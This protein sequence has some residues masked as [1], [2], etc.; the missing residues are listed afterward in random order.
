MCLGRDVCFIL[1]CLGHYSYLQILKFILAEVLAAIQLV[2]CRFRY[3]SKTLDLFIFYFMKYIFIILS[4]LFFLLSTFYNM[5][6]IFYLREYGFVWGFHS[7]ERCFPTSFMSLVISYCLQLY[8]ASRE[9]YFYIMNE[10][11][12]IH[13][14]NESWI[15]RNIKKVMAKRIFLYTFVICIMIVLNCFI[16]K[17]LI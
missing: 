7:F 8:L 1:M 2:E 15:I 16:L 13:I 6:N 11:W 10:S 9:F 5:K 14:M 17:I 12:I 3:Q 4:L